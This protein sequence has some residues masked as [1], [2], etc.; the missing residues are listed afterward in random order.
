MVTELQ[1]LPV[2]V[3]GGCS[4]EAGD[5]EAFSHPGWMREAQTEVSV[6]WSQRCTGDPTGQGISSRSAGIAW[7]EVRTR[8]C[9]PGG[10]RPQSRS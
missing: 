1:H 8:L 7:E 9:Y 10:L 2:P 5:T 6:V 3:S 4:F